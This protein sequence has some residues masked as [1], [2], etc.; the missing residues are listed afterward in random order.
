MKLRAA[1]AGYILRQWSVDCSPDYSLHGRD[2]RWWLK[3]HLAICGVRS[4]VLASGV[5]APES[6]VQ[7]QVMAEQRM[8]LL[9][10][11]A[12]AEPTNRAMR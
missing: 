7:E 3:D 12:S 10:P 1:K 11:V 2:Y 6:T 8:Y 9:D 5:A 4:A